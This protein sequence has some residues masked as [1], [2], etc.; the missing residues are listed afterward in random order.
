MTPKQRI[1][2]LYQQAFA[3]E[4]SDDELRAAVQFLQ[5]QSKKYEGGPASPEPWADLCH[6]LMNVKEFIFIN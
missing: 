4:P 6:V 3:R 2:W 5:T 1:R